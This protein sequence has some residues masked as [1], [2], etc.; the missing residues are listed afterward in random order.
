MKL[1]ST[2][3]KQP[4]ILS[5]L[6]L[7]VV[8]LTFIATTKT[9]KTIGGSMYYENTTLKFMLS[10]KPNS[11][12]DPSNHRFW[13]ANW[14]GGSKLVAGVNVPLAGRQVTFSLMR[15]SWA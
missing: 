6:F 3:L 15:W 8:A 10:V 11:C 13:I 14:P 7:G 4:A 5:A 9:T 1:S 2:M 12:V